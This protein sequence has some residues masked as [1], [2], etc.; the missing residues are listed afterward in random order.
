M[1]AYCNNNAVLYADSTGNAPYLSMIKTRRADDGGYDYIVNQY[2]DPYASKALGEYTVSY[3]GCGAIA[4]YN[5]LISMGNARSF[6]DV[7]SYYNGDSS[8]IFA[9]GQFGILPHQVAGYFRSLGYT[10]VI[11]DIPDFI[12]S[13][14]KTADACIMFYVFPRQETLWGIKGKWPGA[15]FVEYS[16]MNDGYMA[17]NTGGSNGTAAFSSPSDFGYAGSNFYVICIFVYE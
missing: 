16:S 7:L 6:D 4:S 14:S 9:K 1:F 13:C 10:T 5:A 12:E 11:T 3:N 8:R 2:E 15:H 17:R